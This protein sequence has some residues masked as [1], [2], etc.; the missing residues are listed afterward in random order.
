MR[1]AKGISPHIPDGVFTESG[2]ADEYFITEVVI[3]VPAHA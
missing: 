1:V 3:V 2:I